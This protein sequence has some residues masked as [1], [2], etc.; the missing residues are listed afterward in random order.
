M[1]QLKTFQSKKKY[2]PPYCDIHVHCWQEQRN[3]HHSSYG[4]YFPILQLT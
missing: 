2:L 1:Q 3:F 4:T